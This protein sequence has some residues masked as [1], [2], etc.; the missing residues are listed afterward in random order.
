MISTFRRLT[1]SEFVEPK[2]RVESLPGLPLVPER[3]GNTPNR[4]RPVQEMDDYRVIWPRTTSGSRRR[5]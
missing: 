1:G 3:V 5:P 2:G 4:R